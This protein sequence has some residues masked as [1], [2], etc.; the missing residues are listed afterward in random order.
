MESIKVTPENLVAKAR[1]VD[2]KAGE[3]YGLYR[4]FLQDMETLTSSDWTGQEAT[5]FLNQVR[6]FEDDCNKMKELM[7]DYANFMRQTA[8]NYENT[9]SNVRTAIK[10]LQN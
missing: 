5:D 9:Q 6:G 4:G 7:N 1:E 2:G 8:Q 3:Y 10:G